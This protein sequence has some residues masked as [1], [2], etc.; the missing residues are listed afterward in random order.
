M[1]LYL[2]AELTKRTPSDCFF[3]AILPTGI[4]IHSHNNYMYINVIEILIRQMCEC[5]IC[6]KSY[7]MSNLL[8]IRKI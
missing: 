6:E 1:V 2:S 3:L 5:R 8:K 7:L 4:R